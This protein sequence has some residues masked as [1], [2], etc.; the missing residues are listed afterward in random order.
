MPENA[1]PA[2]PEQQKFNPHVAA[3]TA[4]FIGVLVGGLVVGVKS[5]DFMAAR[6]V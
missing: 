4:A 5:K 2:P 1:L 6:E 3:Y